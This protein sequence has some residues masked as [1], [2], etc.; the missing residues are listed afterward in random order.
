MTAFFVQFYKN[1]PFLRGPGGFFLAEQKNAAVSFMDQSARFAP[2]IQNFGWARP[3]QIFQPW[4]P[5]RAFLQFPHRVCA[6]PRRTIPARIS[7]L[8]LF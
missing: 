4:V 3:V 2:K 6:H 8:G 7:I 1:L 5:V